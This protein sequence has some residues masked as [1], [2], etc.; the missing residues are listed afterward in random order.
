M[1][2][3]PV[4]AAAQ[5]RT[6]RLSAGAAAGA[7]FPWD[8]DLDFTAGAWQIDGRAGLS[9]RVLLD[10]AFD[11]WRHARTT[12]YM[13]VPGGLAGGIARIEQTTRDRQDLWQVDMLATASAGR[14]RLAAGG[15][16]G[17]LRY[18][19]RTETNT[20]GCTAGV[21]CGM[22]ESTSSDV[23]GTVQAVGDL[24]ARLAGRLDAFGQTRIVIPLTDPG[25][26]DVRVLAGV[27]WTIVD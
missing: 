1:A 2:A 18:T 22:F 14:L 4:T 6:P 26:G 5:T 27:R 23:A 25:S 9:S 10:V 7:A 21:P 19:R 11:G 13:D 8:G 16:V 17:F 15:G 12:T 20:S 24:D 3:L